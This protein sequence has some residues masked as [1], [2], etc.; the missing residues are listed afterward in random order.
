M[1]SLV[2]FR[3]L[4]G[5][6]AS[7]EF[8]FGL[9]AGVPGGPGLGGPLLVAGV[10]GFEPLPLGRQE[11]GQR[12]GAPG[13]GF[14]VAGLRAG[15]LLPGVGFGL[16]GEPQLAAYVRGRG[17]LGALG[18]EA[19]L[20]APV[21]DGVGSVAIGV[22]LLASALVLA[23]ETRSL[24]TGEAAAVMGPCPRLVLAMAQHQKGQRDEARKTLAA[25]V[26]S[27]DWSAAKATDH[28]TWIAHIL[29]R[30]AETLIR[31]DLPGR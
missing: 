24:L 22:L 20:D 8:G 21:L 11:F 12:P 14:V 10:A 6:S 3:C 23:N 25:A 19:L 1:L 30:E 17:G 26:A 18:L 2:C 27:Y 15:E 16:C 13:S 7:F 31:S 4:R 5:S 9:P 29:R 28:D